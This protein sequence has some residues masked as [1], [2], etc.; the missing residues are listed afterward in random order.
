MQDSNARVPV[1]P[2]LSDEVTSMT[3]L[4]GAIFATTPDAVYEV[5]PADG[6]MGAWH[7]VNTLDLYRPMLQRSDKRLF[8]IDDNRKIILIHSPE[9]STTHPQADFQ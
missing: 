9:K 3:G 8:V 5:V 2:P 6:G 7:L 1:V 4:C